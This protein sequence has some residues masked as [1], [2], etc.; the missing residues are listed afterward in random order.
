MRIVH[1]RT[2]FD[3]GM[4]I[5]IVVFGIAFE[6]EFENAVG[7]AAASD[8]DN[9]V[10]ETDRVMRGEEVD[11]TGTVLFEVFVFD[12]ELVVSH[13]LFSVDCGGG[14]LGGNWEA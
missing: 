2:E 11:S 12:G 7:E 14:L 4:Q 9:S 3:P 5:P 6:G 8:E 10:E 1:V 13:G